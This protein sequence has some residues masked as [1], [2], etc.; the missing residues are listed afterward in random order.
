MADAATDTWVQRSAGDYASAIENELPTGE[1]WSRDPD[2]G[3]MRWVDGCAQIWGDVAAAAALLLV[4][5]ADSRF[6][7]QLLPD[8]ERAFGLP[9][10]CL[11]RGY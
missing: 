11:G 2:G 9:D 10:P 8:W 6:T 4:T 7:T 1:A 5:E 3:L